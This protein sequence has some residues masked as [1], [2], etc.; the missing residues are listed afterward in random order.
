MIV[1]SENSIEKA[2]DKIESIP[3]EAI[4]GYIDNVAKLQPAILAYAMVT[5]EEIKQELA[6]DLLYYALIVFEAF[7]EESGFVPEVSENIITACETAYI[8]KLEQL[9]QADDS[10][11]G[12]LDIFNST[13]QPALLHFLVNDLI[14]D[15]DNETE[16]EIASE[17]G[18]IFS[19]LQIIVES[20][21]NVINKGQS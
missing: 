16:E 3:E 11:A 7:S 14:I 4:Q 2:I 13:A 21:S 20:F 19:T 8:E 12:M 9:E 1:V 6:E 5:G 17:D 10:D 15:E 18:T